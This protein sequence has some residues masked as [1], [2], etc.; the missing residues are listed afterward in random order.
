ML[1]VH[2]LYRFG[3]KKIGV[4]RDVCY[5]CKEQCIA[6]LWKSFHCYH[7][8]WIP[9]IPLGPR[10]E[11]ECTLCGVNPRRKPTIGV[12]VKILSVLLM[13]ILGSVTVS[14]WATPVYQ[15]GVDG[16]VWGLR[17]LFPGAMAGLVWLM[18]IRKPKPE[19][20]IEAR[21][22]LVEPLS[23]RECFYCRGPLEQGL[24]VH[25][26]TCQVTIYRD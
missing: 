2:G 20:S 5:N 9:L 7:L 25:C 14:L 3:L 11:W 10:R 22:A 12:L 19:P 26:P 16:L 24:E 15:I 17:L 18:F 8:F 23:D 21:R 1:V 6:E 13:L 4:R